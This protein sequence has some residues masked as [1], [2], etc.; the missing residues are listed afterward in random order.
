[1]NS[2]WVA[3]SVFPPALPIDPIRARSAKKW[4]EIAGNP[5]FRARDISGKAGV[6]QTLHARKGRKGKFRCD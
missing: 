5:A 6:V 2:A 4:P 3:I 1:M